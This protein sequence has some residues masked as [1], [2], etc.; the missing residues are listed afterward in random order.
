MTIKYIANTDIMSGTAAT[1]VWLLQQINTSVHIINKGRIV[2][3]KSL[4]GLI[5]ANIKQNDEFLILIDNNEYKKQILQI[6]E[7]YGRERI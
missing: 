2:N 1:I 6:F 3:G 5:S 4:V 7:D